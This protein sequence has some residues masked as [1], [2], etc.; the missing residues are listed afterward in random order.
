MVLLILGALTGCLQF[1]GDVPDYDGDGWTDV[2]VTNAGANALL[3][4]RG[5]GTFTETAAAAG[6]DH[7]GWGTSCAFLDIESV[8]LAIFG[9][10]FVQYPLWPLRPG[11]I[12]H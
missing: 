3:R 10:V 2:Y 12:G 1:W 9:Q 8:D 5:D 11:T 4:N 7:T 6:V